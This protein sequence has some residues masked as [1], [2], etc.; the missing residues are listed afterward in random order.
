MSIPTPAVSTNA[1]GQPIQLSPTDT[2]ITVAGDGTIS[3]EN[4]RIG[5]IGLVQPT[6]PM[7]LQA[8]GGDKLTSGSPTTAVANPGLVQGSVED[9][10]VQPMMEMVR[11]MNDLR[12][13]QYVTQMVEAEDQRQQSA[14]DKL[15]QRT[16]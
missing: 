9:S 16:N 8:V 10:N 14:I 12:E 5:K 13:F 6:D 1:N 7:Q 3:S 11:M 15:T 2:R 4:G